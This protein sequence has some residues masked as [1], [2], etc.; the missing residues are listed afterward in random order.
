MEVLYRYEKFK[1]YVLIKLY[2]YEL[3]QMVFISVFKLCV[4]DLFG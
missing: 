3:Q 2:K 1:K 4:S